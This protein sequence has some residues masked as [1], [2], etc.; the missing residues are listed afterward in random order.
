ME[1]AQREYQIFYQ[2]TK[3][4]PE[5]PIPE[6]YI[7]GTLRYLQFLY[8]LDTLES[9]ETAKKIA[10]QAEFSGAFAEDPDFYYFLGM[11][12]M[13]YV[14]KDTEKNIGF[15]HRI[16]ESYAQCLRIGESHR[17]RGEVGTGSFQALY[18]LGLWYELNGQTKLAKDCY[19]KAAGYHYQPAEERLRI[20]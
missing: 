12:Y 2:E 17:A 5:K 16:P 20:L 10:D 19:E 1:N 4:N 14:L 15:L 18:N 9:L 3:D 13:K 8:R 11:F 7:T 6:Y